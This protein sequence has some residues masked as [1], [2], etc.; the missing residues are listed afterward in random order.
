M[1]FTDDMEFMI[2]LINDIIKMKRKEL[3]EFIKQ[4]KL[5]K[6][7]G[8]IDKMELELLIIKF[9]SNKL[10]LDYNYWTLYRHECKFKNHTNI[11]INDNAIT[12]E[13][14]KKLKIKNKLKY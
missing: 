12:E 11:N 7:S 3:L 1:E 5:K 6:K 8:Y 10:N 4:H 14:E 9:F 2:Y 13:L